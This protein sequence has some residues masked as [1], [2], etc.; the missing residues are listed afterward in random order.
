MRVASLLLASYLVGSLPTSYL[1]GRL[2]GVDLR[3]RGSGNLGGTNVYRVL[4]WK[5]AVPVV[6]VD[7]SKGLLPTWLFPTW[8][9]H[10]TAGLALA[11]GLCAIAGHIWSVFLRFHGGK[12]VATSGGV[13]MAL[14]PV[15]VLV[16]G[17]LWAGV[18][19]ATRTVSLASLSAATVIPILAYLF[20]API[21]TVVFSAGL[22]ALVW[23]THRENLGRLRRG[24]ELRFGADRGGEGGT[25]PGRGP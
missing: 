23:Y 12:G 11:Y 13:L 17:L 18:V 15:A 2:A 3:K 22:A 20:D 19:L 10:A 24:E 25:P 9:A 8:D 5:A 21:S 7:V 6:L 16:G 14:A 4:G 1:A